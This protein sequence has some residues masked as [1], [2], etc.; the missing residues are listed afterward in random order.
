MTRAAAPKRPRKITAGR[1]EITL[2]VEQDDT[3][4]RGNALASGDDVEDRACEDEIIDRLNRGDV[5][6]WAVVIVEVKWRGFTG[7]SVLGCCSYRDE[8]EFRAPGGYYASMVSE[9]LASLNA[10]IAAAYD[11]ISS[12][13]P[14]GAQ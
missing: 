3:D 7:R 9:A 1:C 8:A 5:W 2:T 12:L 6:A 13:L 11:N 4:V 14:R 10:Q